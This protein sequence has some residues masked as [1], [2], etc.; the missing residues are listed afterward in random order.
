MTRFWNKVNKTD[1][2]WE[3]Q[4]YKNRKGYGE[5]S[6][7]GKKQSAHRIAYILERGDIPNGLVID[8]LCRNRGCVNPEHLE[9]VTAAENSRRGL[10]KAYCKRGHLRT[11][12][13]VKKNRN[14]KQC[15]NK[16]A[17]ERYRRIRNG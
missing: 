12:E 11:P 15:H 13:N 5:F 16:D 4:A 1:S 14:C 9:I 8:H 17:R 2:C 10:I 3:W 7:N 6:L